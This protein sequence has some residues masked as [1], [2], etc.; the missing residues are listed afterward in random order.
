MKQNCIHSMISLSNTPCK[1]K[2][3]YTKPLAVVSF[4]WQNNGCFK[5]SCLYLCMCFVSFL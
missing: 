1:E 3:E 5:L 2:A 4:G